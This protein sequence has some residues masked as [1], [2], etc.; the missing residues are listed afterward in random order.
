M[1]RLNSPEFFN[2]TAQKQ[3]NIFRIPKETYWDFPSPLAMAGV[4]WMSSKIHSEV[5]KE[6]V[7]QQEI[8]QF[9]DTIFG[10]G[11]S[12]NFPSVVGIS[13]N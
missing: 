9:Y 4:L 12:K 2:I 3:H 6:G 5:Y 10:A 8:E 13:Q 7:V 11:F 1:D